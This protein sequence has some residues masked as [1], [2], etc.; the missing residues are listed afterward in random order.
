MPKKLN[1][2]ILMGGKSSEHEISL[3]SGREVV[4][5]LDRKKYN[6][7]PIVLDKKT[8]PKTLPIT[9]SKFDV[10]FIAMH[11]PYGEDGKIQGLLDV[12]GVPY[13]GSGVLT[14]ATAMDKKTAKILFACAGLKVPKGIVLK[15]GQPQAAILKSL[16]LPIFIKPNDQGSSVGSSKVTKKS[17]LAKALDTAFSYSDEIL[18]EEY[19]DGTEITCAILGNK[20]PVA[21]PLVEIVT[22]AD[23]FDYKAKY[24]PKLTE[25]IVPA[26]ISKDLTRR[27]QE[28]ALIAYKTLGAQGFGRVDM[29]IRG[30]DIFVLELN[31]I[32][33][34]TPV[35]LFPKAAK[36]AGISYPQLLEK[37]IHLALNP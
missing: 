37:L 25:E 20:N 23:F 32:P 6:V 36:A 35:S 26:R 31:T 9:K 10:V 8:F 7:T 17:Q 28:I 34:L 18:I 15:K 14:S 21:L 3:I 5:N 12:L 4:K 1:V 11:G 29:L 19:I 22:K 2:A 27:A 33:G 16:K 13:T 24:D 30:N